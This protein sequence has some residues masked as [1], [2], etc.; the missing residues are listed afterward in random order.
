M[1]WE[2]VPVLPLWVYGLTA[3]AGIGF[4]MLQMLLLRKSAQGEGV[5]KR[6]VFIKM[7]LWVA[8]LVAFAIVS[9]L[10]LLMFTV[11]AT[12]TLICGSF[13]LVRKARRGES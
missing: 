4:G 13:W 1:P 12:L 10:L 8:A 5:Q 6:F 3:A 11:I 2:S 9:I 7:I